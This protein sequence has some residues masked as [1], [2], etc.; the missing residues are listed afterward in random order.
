MSII[1]VSEFST[2]K[3]YKSRQSRGLVGNIITQKISASQKGCLEKI[4][5]VF[6]NS[7]DKIIKGEKTMSKT[8]RQALKEIENHINTAYNL[9]VEMVEQKARKLLKMHPILHEFT[10]AMGLAFFNDKMGNA[11]EPESK[12]Y[13]Q[14]FDDLIHTLEDDF[15]LKVTGEPMRFTADG[16]KITEWGGYDRT[17]NGLVPWEEG[18]TWDKK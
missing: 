4:I 9:A 2:D 12:N 5:K 1:K 8:K 16:P 3:I 13:L 6:K 10:M 11:I 7:A 15:N 17:E 14:Q 18:R